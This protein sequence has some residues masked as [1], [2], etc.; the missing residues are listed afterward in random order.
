MLRRS[1][2]LVSLAFAFGAIAL[3]AQTPVVRTADPI[4][5]GLQLTDFPRTIKI[6]DRVYTYEGFHA[7]PEKF[8]T[9]NMFVVTD[10]G[11]LVAD[12]QGSPAETKGLV[13]AIRKV[14]NKPITTVVIASD[15]GDHTAGNASF[16]AGVHYI[17]HPNSKAI[18]D[19]SAA[20]AASAGREGGWTLPADAE[21]VADRKNLEMGGEQMQIL[22]LGRSH[23]GGDLAVWL[24]R[25]KILFLSEIY[26]NRVFPAMRSAYPSEWLAALDRA[27]AMKAEVYVA[28]HGFTESGPVSREEIRAYHKA[29][30][31]VIAE[32]TRL[33][34]A[35]VPV[36]E[37]AKQ[38]NWGE[39]ASWTLASSQGPIAIRKVYEELDGKLK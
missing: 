4:K 24:P 28:G 29:L 32:A 20:A 9:T 25:E 38:A 14:T 3:S 12:G 16:P 34:N 6:A 17:I 2:T 11:V 31:A 33:H 39:Y 5:R 1:I 18:L 36:E 27:E 30:A 37:A 21:L 10:A 22:F 35:G 23:T 7:G 26:L 15:H 8:T 13:D 19:R